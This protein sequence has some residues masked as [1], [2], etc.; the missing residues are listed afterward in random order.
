M[1]PGATTR[2]LASITRAFGSREAAGTEG[3]TARMTPSLISTSATL[4]IPLAGSITRPPAISSGGIWL[5]VAIRQSAPEPC[6]TS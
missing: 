5:L 2:P 6:P 3:V 4:S 1:K